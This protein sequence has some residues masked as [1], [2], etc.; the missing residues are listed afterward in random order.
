MSRHWPA[1]A[2]ALLVAGCATTAAQPNA[3]RPG[4]TA[5]VAPERLIVV[6]VTNE[7]AQIAAR[8]GSTPRAYDGFQHY[9]V[10]PAARATVA[11]LA[12]DYGLKEVTAWPIAPLR[13][14]CVVFQIPADAS[15]SALLGQLA[16]EKRV[17]LAQAMN[18]FGTLGETYNDPYVSLQSGFERID[19]ADAHR[20]SHGEGVRVAI[21]DT[22]VD[23]TH[24]ELQ[25]RVAVT[26]NFV[27]ADDAQFRHDRHGTEVAGVIAAIAN[28]HVGIVG[29]APGVKLM[30]YKA[31]WQLDAAAD[32][33]RCNSFTLARALVAA[34]DDHAQIVNMS[35]A[36]PVDHLLAALVQQGVRRGIIFVGAVPHA[37]A[38][39]LESFPADVPGVLAVDTAEGHALTNRPLLAPGREILTLVPEGHYDFAS[40]SSLATAHVTGTV[41]LLLAQRPDLESASIY[42]LLSRT[43]MRS[44]R[45]D[46]VVESI[47]ACAALAAIV[48]KGGCETSAL[49]ANRSVGAT[50]SV[51]VVSPVPLR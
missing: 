20:W 14:H 41:A 26:R 29:I 44:D 45:G 38:A 31:C 7:T 8:A 4:D 19:A 13:V 24:P 35:L 2:A 46:G 12:R 3:S 36:G 15:R 40:G 1:I 21:V 11:A 43:S 16:H 9:G 17:K 34:L 50:T 32:Q 42:E 49:L 18:T 27:D 25:G 23:V 39:G 10:S 5:R 30:A 51:A 28:N 48:G 37:S 22:G 33:A 6:T 47:N